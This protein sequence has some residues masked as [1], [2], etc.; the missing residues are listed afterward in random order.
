M[1]EDDKIFLRF[2]SDLL[3]TS[4]AFYDKV[5]HLYPLSLTISKKFNIRVTMSTLLSV[6][7]SVCS[8]CLSLQNAELYVR[9]VIIKL[10]RRRE[11]GLEEKELEVWLDL[12]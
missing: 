5:S 2:R 10:T 12:F 7:M 6:H 9:T 11:C 3:K 4:A 8:V 1:V